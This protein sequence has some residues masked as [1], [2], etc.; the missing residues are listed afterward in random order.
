MTASEC[1]QRAAECDRL[2]RATDSETAHYVMRA[3]A[4]QWR[5]MAE[6]N[7]ARERSGLAAFPNSAQPN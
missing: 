6:A 3:A 5:R 7:M 4:A 1:L 2:A